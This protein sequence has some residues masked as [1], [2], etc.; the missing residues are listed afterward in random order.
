MGLGQDSNS[1]H[2]PDS[3]GMRNAQFGS[4]DWPGGQTVQLPS[5][6]QRCF[7]SNALYSCMILCV[8]EVVT[9]QK[10]NI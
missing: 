6:L 7:F 1:G 5:H 4:Q 8:Q 9:L 2:L 3:K 10:K